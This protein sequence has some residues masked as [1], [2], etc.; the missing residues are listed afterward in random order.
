M[1]ER[2]AMREPVWA[3]GLRGQPYGGW[4]IELVDAE[5]RPC[6]CWLYPSG[7]AV[8]DLLAVAE[9]SRLGNCPSETEACRSGWSPSPETSAKRSRTGRG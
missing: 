5:G 7:N 3:R 9:H 8:V 2:S 4:P 1:S 6:G